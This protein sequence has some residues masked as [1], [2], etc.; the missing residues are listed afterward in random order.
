[1]RRRIPGTDD[2]IHAQNV[3]RIEHGPRRPTIDR[4]RIEGG[5][6][7]G[8]LEKAH[9]YLLHRYRNRKRQD[10][11]FFLL[12]EQHQDGQNLF[13]FLDLFQHLNLAGVHHRRIA[14]DQT[15]EQS[16]DQQRA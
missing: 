8:P 1:M 16:A 7:N 9:G 13:E 4:C 12:L 14:D 5:L 11:D 3:P 6:R 10:F 15:G 2:W